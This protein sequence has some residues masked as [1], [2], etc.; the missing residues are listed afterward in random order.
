MRILLVEDDKS[1]AD[2]TAVL[3]KQH[4]VV[5]AAADGQVGW[6]FAAAYDYDLILLDV[7]PPKWMALAFVGNYGEKAIK[8]PSPAATARDTGSDKV[9]GRC[10]SR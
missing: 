3:T 8:C 6:E 5:D 1:I 2:A 10:R 7:I 9:M 4:Y